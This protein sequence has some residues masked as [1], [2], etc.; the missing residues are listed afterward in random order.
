VAADPGAAGARH[1]GARIAALG[2]AQ[3]VSWGTLYY[4]IAVLGAPMRAELGVGDMLLFGAFSAGLFVSGAASPLV[5][6][7]I[8]AGRARE[9]LGAGSVVG[10]LA[11]V[12]LALAQGPV[13]VC[14]GWILAGVAMALCL[15]DPAFATLHHI[16]GIHYRRAI[17][18]LT[19]FGGFASTV[20][21]PASQWL[22]DAVG[23]RAT[24][25]V[26]AVLHVAVCLPLHLMAI[27]RGARHAETA[28]PPAAAEAPHVT[29][30]ARRTFMWLAIALAGAAFIASAV[31][32]HLIG[33]MTT[34]GIPA[35]D[36]VLIGALFGPMQVAGRIAEF[37]H[38]RHLRPRTVGTLAFVLLALA[39]ALLTQ[40]RGSTAAA[41]GFALLYGVSNGV[42]TIVRGTVPA[43]LFGR[44]E[45]GTLLGRLAQPQLIARAV[46]PVMLTLA[47]PF[48]PTRA[49]T[50]CLLAAGGLVSL[51]AYQ[52]AIRGRGDA[53]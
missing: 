3:I 30:A 20:F 14:A 18:A 5:G 52:L 4:T 29:A 40:M 36:A 46:A 6:R 50:L 42:M 2:V 39:L 10:A 33:F 27:P 32:A 24:F 12:A 34:A 19:L 37:S 35:G 53:G 41:V 25:A 1:L 28:P 21:W 15:Y 51:C 17:T 16:S 45:F 23:W 48:D 8:D 44:R 26:Y 31:T 22:S 38:G 49:I 43:E 13:S 47:F 11:L 9:V 7:L